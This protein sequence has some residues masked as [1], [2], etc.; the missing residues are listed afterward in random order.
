[1]SMNEKQKDIAIWTAMILAAMLVFPPFEDGYRCGGYQFILRVPDACAMNIPRLLIQWLGVILVGGILW[2][3]E[4]EK[5]DK[6]K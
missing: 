6:E 2:L 4:S 1:M 3:S 5:D